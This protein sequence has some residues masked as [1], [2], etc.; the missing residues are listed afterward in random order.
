M[1]M[2]KTLKLF[3][4]AVIKMIKNLQVQTS[5]GPIMVLVSSPSQ[6]EKRIVFNFNN[7]VNF[8]KEAFLH[9]RGRFLK[10]D[11]DGHF[12]A[13]NFLA[14]IRQKGVPIPEESR[15][16]EGV[17]AL[18]DNPDLERYF[19]H[20]VLGE[21]GLLNRNQKNWLILEQLRP[22]S[23]PWPIIIQIQYAQQL[24]NW[25]AGFMTSIEKARVQQ[26]ACKYFSHGGC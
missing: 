12:T 5:K 21:E 7:E 10:E 8:P 24:E 1:G 23:T 11:F 19:P 20:L 16:L 15:G 26:K 2:N 25:L 18:L 14:L 9:L 6:A 22:A 4:S 17:N 3:E 13:D